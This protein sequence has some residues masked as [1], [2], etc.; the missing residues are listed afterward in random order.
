MALSGTGK[1][2]VAPPTLAWGRPVAVLVVVQPPVREADLL[3]RAQ[4]VVPASAPGGRLRWETL[5]RQRLGADRE[6]VFYVVSSPGPAGSA[7]ARGSDDTRLYV[8]VGAVQ[9]TR[10]SV[11]MIGTDPV[12]D[13]DLAVTARILEAMLAVMRVA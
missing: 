12:R 10:A 7:R 13:P 11:V 5:G 9:G 6:A 8:M 1:I 2:V 4:A 3:A